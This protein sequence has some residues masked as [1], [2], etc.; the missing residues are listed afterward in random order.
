MFTST[1][2]HRVRIDLHLN[3]QEYI[4]MDYIHQ[5]MEL[6]Q[7][8][9][10][11]KAYTDIG[12]SKTN[13]EVMTNSLL[14]KGYLELGNRPTEAWLK[15]FNHN[16]Q[17]ETLWKIHP[18]GKKAIAKKRWDKLKGKVDFELIKEWLIKYRASKSPEK[19]CFLAGLDVI[20][21][22]ENKRWLDPIIPDYVKEEERKQD[23]KPTL[24]FF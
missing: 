10:Q 17:F 8:A 12:I 6:D 20:L 19:Q 18:K 13:W 2:H 7:V 11:E 16:D 24:K 3:I 15:H 21:V 5:M 23:N 14:D 9:T 22:P 4:V 1:I